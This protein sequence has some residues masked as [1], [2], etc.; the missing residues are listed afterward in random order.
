MT[1]KH[2]KRF[3]WWMWLFLPLAP[4]FLIALIL[5]MI[6]MG[7]TALLLVFISALFGVDPPEWVGTLGDGVDYYG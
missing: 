2:A 5:C 7:I 4:L 1:T 6:V 3:R